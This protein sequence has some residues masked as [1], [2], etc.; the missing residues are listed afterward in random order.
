MPTVVDLEVYRLGVH[1]SR[2][3][4]TVYIPDIEKP[5]MVLMAFTLSQWAGDHPLKRIGTLLRMLLG[6][7]QSNLSTPC[8]LGRITCKPRPSFLRLQ[9]FTTK[10]EKR[11]MGCR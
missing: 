7:G 2:A 8:D 1:G 11:F 9:G 3:R 10:V 5:T 6:V 4:K